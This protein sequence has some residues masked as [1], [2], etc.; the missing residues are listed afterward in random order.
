MCFESSEVDCDWGEGEMIILIFWRF[1]RELGRVNFL[2]V[3]INIW[4]WNRK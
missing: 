2:R 3:E 4:V 1:I